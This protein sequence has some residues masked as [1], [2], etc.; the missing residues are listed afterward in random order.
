[1]TSD[2]DSAAEEKPRRDDNPYSASL[3]EQSRPEQE[4]SVANYPFTAA[5]SANVCALIWLTIYI[6]YILYMFNVPFPFLPRP[7]KDPVAYHVFVNCIFWVI[8]LLPFFTLG[9]ITFAL[10]YGNVRSRIIVV[11]PSIL[12]G[13]LCALVL[14]GLFRRYVMGIR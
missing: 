13:P 5:V 7:G 8:T 9:L 4:I 3:V 11:L 2:S 10:R 12:F 1:M 6:G 14:W